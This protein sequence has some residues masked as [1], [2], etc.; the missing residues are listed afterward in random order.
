MPF[1]DFAVND[2]LTVIGSVGDVGETFCTVSS[3][4]PRVKSPLRPVL[5]VQVA[6]PPG[7][8]NQTGLALV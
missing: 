3:R 2:L 4:H 1:V 8:R 7:S 5:T 6:F